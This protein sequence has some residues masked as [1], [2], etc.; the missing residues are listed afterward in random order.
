MTDRTSPNRE[1]NVIA[2]DANEAQR[3]EQTA[4]AKGWT[5]AGEDAVRIATAKDVRWMRRGAFW[6]MMAFPLALLALLQIYLYPLRLSPAE[7]AEGGAIEALAMPMTALIVGTY[8]SI[9]AIYVALLFGLF[10][11]AAESGKKE[12]MADMHPATSAARG[13]FGGGE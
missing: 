2:G 1:H 12:S 7:V 9:T 8:L 4:R 5:E 13:L 3:H 10:R 11:S 6:F